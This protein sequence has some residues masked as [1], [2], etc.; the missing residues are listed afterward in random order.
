MYSNHIDKSDYEDA[1]HALPFKNKELVNLLEVFFGFQE[2][3]K[4]GKKN[5]FKHYDIKPA[6]DEYLNVFSVRNDTKE[7]ELNKKLK[8]EWIDKYYKSRKGYVWLLSFARTIYFEK[9]DGADFKFSETI[10]ND[11]IACLYEMFPILRENLR[12]VKEKMVFKVLLSIQQRIISPN[13]QKK[14]F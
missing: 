14:L 6:F 1:I 9:Y 10:F 11:E 2:L 13:K 12:T 7:K 4:Q 8:D 5:L 3:S